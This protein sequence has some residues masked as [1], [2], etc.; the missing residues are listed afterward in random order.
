[1]AVIMLLACVEAVFPLVVKYA[2]DSGITPKN[3]T[4]IYYASGI[5]ILLVVLQAVLVC[6]F[7]AGCGRVGARVMSDLRTRT[8]GHLQE[9]SISYFDKTPAG[10]ILSRVM[11]DSQRVGETISWGAVDFV[12]GIFSMILMAAAML[13]VHWKLALAVICFVPVIL[14][15]SVYFQKKILLY[16][17]KSRRLNSEITAGYSEGISGVKVIKS[18]CRENAVSDEFKDLTGNMYQTA[19]KSA[20]LSSVYLPIVHITGAICCALVVAWGG[21]GV[22]AGGISLGTLVAFV[23]YAER[24]FHP[25]DE[26]ARIFGQLQE[27]QASAER[28]FAL[29]E[30]KPDIN[31]LK[32]AKTIGKF[33]GSVRFCNV[34]FSYDE[35]KSILKNFNLKVHSGQCIALVGPT[36][37]GKSTITNL[38]MRFYDPIKG[39][40][41]ID[42][43]DIRNFT[44]KALRSQISAV[45]QTP[46]LFSG[47]VVEN[48]RYGRLD[49]STEEVIH[50]SKLTG[51]HEYVSKLPM[52]Y[53]TVLTEGGEPFSTGEK[54]LVSLTRALLSDPAI[55]VLDEATSSVDLDTEK[56]IQMAIKRILKGR[57][58]FIV[59]HRLST[60]QH[61][62]RIIVINRGRI[63]ESG[64][65]SELIARKGHYF[66]LY[67]QQFLS[68]VTNP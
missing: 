43:S 39:E 26:I 18:L 11:S 13:Y 50:V 55:F 40:I 27:T 65:H 30:T 38:L 1:M 42:G 15:V 24:F 34:E 52:G 10:W 44:Q 8:Y 32:N 20:I 54:Q 63:E 37:G 67:R 57:T 36:G 41:Q 21:K 28:L 68:L 45:L 12:W 6:C 61:A 33:A 3:K 7:I 60:I 2:I 56:R 49:A 53:D 14:A 47:T 58:S 48:I 46:H 9:L 5:Y 66:Q 17:R 4:I 62:D 23:S 31:D 59:A 22:I 35:K 16:Y 25:A 19:L 29:L 51:L 64:T